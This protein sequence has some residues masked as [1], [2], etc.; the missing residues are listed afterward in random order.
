MRTA[1]TSILERLE[2]TPASYS[3]VARE[4]DRL[5]GAG[6]R[7]ITIAIAATF[8]ADLVGP[9]LRVEAARRGLDAKVLFAPY[10]QLELQLLDPSSALHRAKPDV[11]VVAA[12]FEDIAPELGATYHVLSRDQ[13]DAEIRQVENRFASLLAGARSH[14]SAAVLVF[15]CAPP[16]V[17]SAGLA[18]AGLPLAQAAAVSLLNSAISQVCA[19]VTQC[20]VFDYARVVMDFGLGRWT[21]Q[22]LLFMARIPFGSPAQLELGRCLARY[23]SAIVSAPR[24]CLVVDLDNTLWGGVLGEDGLAGIRLGEDFPGNAFK[25]FQRYLVA[26]R[27]RGVL[28]AIAS[29]NN[30][31]EVRE[32]FARHPDCILKLSDFSAL[33]IHWRDKASSLA[34]IARTLNIGTDALVFFDDSATECAWVRGEMPEVLVVEGPKSPVDYV[35]ALER[36]EAFDHLLITHEDRH[37][38]EQYRSGAQRREAE[39][40]T[41]SIDE[42]LRTLELTATVGTVSD[43]T[44]PRVA[45][46]IGKTN[47]FNLTGRR[48]SASAVA[49][50]IKAGAVAVWMR[51]ADRYGDSGLVGVAMA[52]E[53]APGQWRIDTFLL[54]C[55]VIGRRAETVLLAALAGRVQAA[56]G[57]ELLGEY[58]ATDR[59]TVA[60]SFFLDHGFVASGDGYWRFGLRSGELQVPDF[61]V[62]HEA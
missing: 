28:L 14:S 59:N 58:V 19:G 10:G 44:L 53:E 56:G 57:L 16:V 55:R 2:P 18:D 46:L 42:F 4:L 15:N 32:V 39:A 26:L 31:P 43:E 13:V 49:E 6:L 40:S 11:I 61:F 24:K 62:I 37:R 33:E 9:Y 27:A 7:S 30:E 21:D 48:H 50:L 5:A 47:Q 35:A 1:V 52:I 51:V 38:A 34:S 60:S 23:V 17:A 8:T 54:S 25:A 36:A 20:H 41:G 3:E 29:K 12:R 22:R 45:Q